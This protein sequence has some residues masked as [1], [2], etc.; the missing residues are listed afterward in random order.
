MRPA[1][2]PAWSARWT[3]RRRGR[4]SEGHLR[5]HPAEASA[6]MITTVESPSP[7]VQSR[8]SGSEA[9][10]EGLTPASL[11]ATCTRPLRSD[12]TRND[13]PNRRFRRVRLLR[14]TRR[15]R[16]RGDPHEQRARSR[17]ASVHPGI[18]RVVE[19]IRDQ[20][21]IGQ[22]GLAALQQVDVVS[23][24][25]PGWPVEGK[26]IAQVEPGQRRYPRSET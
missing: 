11:R 23:R 7:M 22:I 8:V 21:V 13:A 9:T 1:Q 3:P 6:F 2:P 4:R 18:D 17:G 10:D 16:R 26:G 19:Q 12:A 25:G 24:D 20:Q 14:D 15:R 5:R